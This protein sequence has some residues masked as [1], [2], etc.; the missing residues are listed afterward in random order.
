MPRATSKAIV[1][2]ITGKG[3][4]TSTD[5]IITD[6]DSPFSLTAAHITD[7]NRIVIGDL[8]AA[9]VKIVVDPTIFSGTIESICIINKSTERGILETAIPASETL[10][11]GGSNL[12][13]WIGEGPVFIQGDSST[14]V[15]I[16]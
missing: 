12:Y 9:E 8:S 3:I 6:A 4:L 7:G 15:E 10:S 5:I 2:E 13:F 1:V 16:I 11:D 14:N